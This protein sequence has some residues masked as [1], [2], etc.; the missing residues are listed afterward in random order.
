MLLELPGPT[1]LALEEARGGAQSGE[2]DWL[3]IE[4]PGVPWRNRKAD[5]ISLPDQGFPRC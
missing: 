1:V 3:K 5:S 2:A 4:V